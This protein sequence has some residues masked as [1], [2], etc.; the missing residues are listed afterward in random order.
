MASVEIATA[1][2]LIARSLLSMPSSRKLL[3][4]S[5][6][7][8]TVMDPP[9]VWFCDPLTPWLAPGTSKFSCRKLRPFSGSS[10]TFLLSTTLPTVEESVCT[11]PTVASTAT[12][13]VTWPTESTTSW[14][15]LSSTRSSILPRSFFLKLACSTVRE[16]WPTGNCGMEYSPSLLVSSVRVRPVA[17]CR[18]VTFAPGTTAPDA[19]VTVPR[20]VP[21]TLWPYPTAAAHRAMHRASEKYRLKCILPPGTQTSASPSG[22]P[23]RPSYTMASKEERNRVAVDYEGAIGPQSVI[24][25][26]FEI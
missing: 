25:H 9:C 7:P 21:R 11:T 26:T 2:W 4:C 1:Y 10:V 15:S 18:A 19:S 8:L 20:I 16:Y 22:N 14:R 3:A 12:V 13:S 24:R 23:R 5:R 6:A 17:V